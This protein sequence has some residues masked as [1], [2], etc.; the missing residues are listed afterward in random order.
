[1]AVPPSAADSDPLRELNGQVQDL[2]RRILVL[3]QCLG[4]KAVG[5]ATPEVRAPSPAAVPEVPAAPHLPPNILP[6]LGKVLLAIAGAYVLRALTDFGVMPR[7]AGTAIGLL[8]ALLWLFLA[9]RLPAEAQFA[10]AMTCSASMLIIGPLLWEA[11]VRLKAMSTW[12]SAGVLAGTAFIALALSWRKRGIIISAVVLV[13]STLLAA[14]L[15]VATHDLLP[16][17]L[18]LLALAA[19]AEFATCRD[20]ATGSR[21]ITAI[22]ADSAVLLFSSLMAGEHGLPEAYVPTSTVAALAAQLL[23]IAIYLTSALTQTVTRRRTLAFSEMAQTAC[24]L[25]IGMGGIAWVFR[26]NGAAMVALGIS[27]LI[28]GIACYA[29]SFKLFEQSKWNFR[30]WAT[31][32]LLLVL[33]GTSLLFS[34]FWVLWCGC[35]VACCWAAMAARRPTLGLH[36]AVYLLLGSAVSGASSQPLSQLLGIGKLPFHSLVSLGVLAAAM[37]SWV[38]IGRSWAGD[39]ARW[40]KHIASFAIAANIVWILSGVAVRA[41][42][43]VWQIPA[44]RPSGRIPADT[45]GTVVLTA[46][47]VALAWAGTRWQLRELVWLAYG[48]M[49][50]GAWKLAARDFMNERDVAL[51]IS[52]I[53]YGGA[54]ILL[55]R[56]KYRTRWGK[57]AEPYNPRQTS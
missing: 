23:L 14:A 56:M 48:F 26:T 7:A 42:I 6:V 46:F 9:A 1:M 54:L 45:L 36:G 30:A 44:G 32:G 19:A 25:L 33:A 57:T 12:T 13:S 29:L 38:A 55:P 49:G 40:R 18:A 31:Y 2:Q 4:G 34:G 10:S 27:G 22:A 8:Y 16:F 52:L 28:G 17:T 35:A 50:L 41:L 51:V 43:L 21:W 39:V 37:L 11:C 3:E 5:A 24:A 47:A 15:L 53:F 20:H